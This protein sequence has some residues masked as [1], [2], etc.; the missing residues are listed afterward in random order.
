MPL[1]IIKTPKT[2]CTYIRCEIFLLCQK[3]FLNSAFYSAFFFSQRNQCSRA[4]TG[5]QA[6]A[7]KPNISQFLFWK[8]KFHWNTA[9]LICLHIVQGCFCI[10]TAVE[11]SLQ[12]LYGFQSQKYFLLD[13]LWKKTAHPCFRD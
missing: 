10:M 8:M 2:G 6:K 11:S 13:P 12:R 5:K 9:M 4:G 7:C 1:I 3:Y